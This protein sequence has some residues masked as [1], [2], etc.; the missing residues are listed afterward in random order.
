MPN[1][2]ARLIIT[3]IHLHQAKSLAYGLSFVKTKFFLKMEHD[4]IFIKNIFIYNILKDMSQDSALKIVRF[5]RRPNK[6]VNC[7]DGYYKKHW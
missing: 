4:H 7:D 5:N 3:K 1:I 2:N 6:R